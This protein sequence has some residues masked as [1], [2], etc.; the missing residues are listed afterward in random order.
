MRAWRAQELRSLA[1]PQVLPAMAVPD[2][3]N[4]PGSA[5]ESDTAA[6]VAEILDASGNATVLEARARRNCHHALIACSRTQRRTSA[7]SG[8]LESEEVDFAAAV[9]GDDRPAVGRERARGD[10]QF[11][12][13]RGEKSSC[14]EIPAAHRAVLGRGDR[15]RRI[16]G[17][18]DRKDRPR[19]SAQQVALGARG[20]IPHAQGAADATGHSNMPV[21]RNDDGRH[22]QG[23]PSQQRRRRSQLPSVQ[24]PQRV[25][26]VRRPIGFRRLARLLWRLSHFDRPIGVHCTQRDVGDLWNAGDQ[27]ERRSPP[28]RAHPP[29]PWAR[30]LCR[31]PP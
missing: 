6:F 4:R 24:H 14:P 8:Q 25:V 20:E 29:A 11:A 1:A 31:P 21:V 16:L 5:F 9:A 19:M 18:R 12:G 30:A 28:P 2:A 23:M 22:R 7:R 3:T 13:E 15:K 17:K 10:P 27:H 26:V